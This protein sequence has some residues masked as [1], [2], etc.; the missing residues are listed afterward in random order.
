MAR[1]G[2]TVSGRWFEA[3]SLGGKTEAGL[4][5]AAQQVRRVRASLGSCGREAVASLQRGVLH[6][7]GSITP[8]LRSDGDSRIPPPAIAIH[9]RR[10]DACERWAQ[11][12]DAST[13]PRPC[14]AVEHY[15]A[16]ARRLLGH[17]R[18]LH[19]GRHV[20]GRPRLLVA[21]DSA[22]ALREL[23]GAAGSEMEVRQV[24]TPRGEAWGGS[25]EGAVLGVRRD[26][27]QR[28][29]FIEERNARGLV[30]RRLVFASL[31]ADLDLL[32]SADAIVGTS[33]SWVSRLSL[34]AIA[35]ELGS[36][37]PHELLD[38]PL[39]SVW[40]MRAGA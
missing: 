36:T 13:H 18:R 17:L 21:S 23:A 8:L 33:A 12:G 30:N 7:D 38:A 16:A 26:V 25:S 1:G 4:W 40:T 39:G 14:F 34:L 35:G 31:F 15:L 10:G 24:I 27:A 32:A 5:W 9:I 20:A 3:A 2:S 6:P 19:P 29:H 11:P 37:P 22:E 28:E